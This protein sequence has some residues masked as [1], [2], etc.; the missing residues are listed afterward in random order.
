ME[1]YSVEAILIATDKTFSST[2]SSAERSMVGVNKQSG[3]LGDGLDKSTTK[4]NQLGKSILSI[5]AGVGAVKLVSTAVN[6]VK[7]SVEGAINR[8]D[9][10]NKYPV[11]MKALGYSTEDVDRSMTK[12]SDGIDGL[13]TSLDEIVSNTQQLAI[14]TGSLSKGT[15]TAIAL[16]DAFLASGASTA[17]ATRGMQQYIQMLGKGEVDMQSWRTLQETMPIA[18]DKVAKSFKEQGV[19]SVNQL[20]D[21]LKEG[22]ITFNEFNNRL[23]ELD[24]GVGGFADL[25]KKNSKGIKTSWANI[26]TATVKGVTTVIK[27]FD[28]LSKAV[29]GKNIAENLDS[30]KNVVNI[31]FKAIDAAIQSTIPLMKLFGKAITSIGTAL[32]PLLPTIASF[33]ATFTA[34]KVIQ[35][36]TGYIKQSE[37]AIK[38]YTTAI[39]LYNGISKLATLSTTAL[40]RAWML[41]LAADKANSAAIAI[42]TGLLVAQNT[43]VGILTGTIS[44]AT[45]ATTVFSTAMKLLMGP[46]GWVTA[47]IGGLVAVGVNLWKW[48]NKETESTKAVKKEQENLMKTTDDLIKKNQEHAQSRKDEAI[49]LENTKEKYN[50]MISEM[51]T[52]AAKEK[53][54][55]GEKKRMTEIVEEL[56]GKMT[57]L[58]LVY[59]EQSN[60]LSEMPGKIQQQMDAYSALD[61]A[62]KAQEDINKMLQQRNDNEAK[63][64]EINAAREKWNQTLKESGG[65][66]KEARENIAELGEQE[67]V[68]MGVQEDLR[69]DI[70]NTAKTHESA[71]QTASQAVA[72]GVLEQTVSYNALSGKTKETMDAMRA[73]YTSLE[74][75]VG[76]AFDVIEQKQ[77]IS[78]DQM[79]ANLQKN[80]EAV[81]QWGQNI[82]TLAE[83]HVD[84]GLL[85]QLR[86]MGP[87]GAAQ[88]AELVNASDEQLQRLN[89]VYR[90]TGETSMNAMK[91][92]Y[93]LGKNG[94]NEEIASLIPTQKDTLMTQ[95]KNTNFNDIG[96]SVTEDFKAGIENGRNA[97]AEMTKGI[98]PQM[99]T[100]MKGEVEKANFPDIGKAIPQGLEKGI[101]ANKQLPVKTSNQMI[102]DVVSGARKGLDSHSPSR[103]FHSIGEDVDSGLSNGIEQNAMNPVRAVES[104]VDKIISAMDKL[105]S[106]MN[107]IGA[108]A[109]DGLTNGINANANSALS[110][111]RGVADQI[112]STM[113]SAMDIHSPSRVMRDEVGKMIPAGVAVGIDK[114]SNFVEKSMQRLSKKVA[115]PALDNLNSNLS[116][117]GGSQSL[118][119]AGD[120]SSK[121]TVEVPII[122]DSSEVA[123]VIAKPMSKELQNQQD[124]KNVSLGRRR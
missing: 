17:D 53:L 16:N 40:G 67:K 113:K 124:K 38:A 45:V 119:F 77:A 5:G 15:D 12:L 86:K 49:E 93:Q 70:I 61:K 48:L 59:D 10:L 71:M 82:S 41:N 68:L 95:I 111:A 76:S 88:A 120:V 37:L 123:R 21:A 98:V 19:N 78:V 110:A 34:L 7:D 97:V 94:V 42:K 102:D 72:N 47:A 24:K 57:G 87:E 115:M 117:S 50:S 96:R 33:A 107:S 22:D 52:L 74:T 109:I 46:I 58:N 26:K 69:N 11:V 60:K 118:A 30:L 2:M 62:S 114:Y 55:N 122:F 106:E 101:G 56:N 73:E 99:G 1:Q 54:S 28:E 108:N 92:G 105:P 91:E 13:P 44:L 63:L 75:K 27:S 23:I 80:Q 121:F 90:N 81:A 3:E 4:G 35:Q 18:M 85:E 36:V 66:T 103:V 20:Y 83:R 51:A 43:I 112:V 89:D 39:S 65:N 29:T 6:M 14:S 64:M 100:D 31:T 84:Q 32:T 104:I 79:A 9:T 116:F 25:A 8:F